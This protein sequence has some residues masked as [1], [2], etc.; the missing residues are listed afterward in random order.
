MF[1]FVDLKQQLKQYLSASQIKEITKAY[2]LAENLHHGQIRSNGDPY[3]THPL[4]AA[5]ILADMRMDYQSIIAAMLHDVLE[6]TSVSK[7]ELIELFN[8]KI[9]ELVD[10]VSKLDQLKFETREEA[11][12]E[13]LRKMML[14]MAKDVRVILVKLADRLHNMRTLDAKPRDNQRR[15]ALETLEIYAPIANR[16]G[17]TPQLIDNTLYDAFGQRQISTIFTELNQ[18]HVILEVEPKLKSGLNAF[19]SLYF[20]SS[21]GTPVPLSAMVS[22]SETLGPLAIN[23]QGQFPV[24][25]VSFNLAPGAALGDAVNAITHAKEELSIPDNIETNFE[26]AAKI[27][28]SSLSNEGWLLAAAIIVVYIVLGILYES[29]I[30]PITILSTLPSATLGALLALQIAGD[31]LSV[32]ALIG[33]ILLIGIVMKNAIMMIDFALDLERTHHKS[34]QDAI[35]EAALLRFRPIVMTTFAA[36]FWSTTFSLWLWHGG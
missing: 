28:Q 33:I 30:H 35:Y 2:K 1:K 19:Q 14:A 25:T 24:A 15:I 9:A 6:D 31:D 34:P 21:S 13:N 10:G 11:Q 8:I 5:K 22:I 16:L 3:I 18:Y 32:I 29:Y 4:A 36:F 23:R 7:K 27:F 17:I 12:A 26:G 20:N